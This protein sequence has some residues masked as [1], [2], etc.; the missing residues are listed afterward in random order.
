VR[1]K[2]VAAVLAF[3]IAGDYMMA[4]TGKT[5]FGIAWVIFGVVRI[6]MHRRTLSH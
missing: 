5:I 1:E 3:V 6:F 4:Q 2:L